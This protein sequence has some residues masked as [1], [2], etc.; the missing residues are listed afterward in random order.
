M[1]ELW[2]LDG[3]I[4]MHEGE[5]SHKHAEMSRFKCEWVNEHFREVNL[6][7]VDFP[8]FER[9]IMSWIGGYEVTGHD[10]RH[11]KLINDH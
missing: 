6:Y 11:P 1:L 7:R 5:C 3:Q 8:T 10:N 2:Q 4:N 9:F